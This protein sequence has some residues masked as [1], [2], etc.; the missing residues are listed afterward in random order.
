MNQIKDALN[1]VEEDEADFKNVANALH[2]L[3]NSLKES[4]ADKSEMSQLRNQLITAQLS[5]NDGHT[6]NEGILDYRGLRKILASY[7][8]TNEINK[9]FE[10][11]AEKNLTFQRLDHSEHMIEKILI[12]VDV[13]W[14]VIMDK[15]SSQKLPAINDSCPADEKHDCTALTAIE[16]NLLTHSRSYTPD[17]DTN[18]KGT[19]R[20]AYHLSRPST[21]SSP[22]KE[23]TQGI[24]R[25]TSAG[26]AHRPHTSPAGPSRLRSITA[27]R[28]YRKSVVPSTNLPSIESKT[29]VRDDNGNL[30]V[31]KN[32]NKHI[33]RDSVELSTRRMS[34]MSFRDGKATST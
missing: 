23:V 24:R 13:I 9:R 25:V 14:T 4:K 6:N 3:F 12:A 15:Q 11:K 31:G 19:Q 20:I 29:F 27:V 34:V 32:E 21:A 18:K 22:L 2:G 17:K 26:A 16:S 30:F 1:S 7:S 8:K 33:I 5:G 10:D 28:P